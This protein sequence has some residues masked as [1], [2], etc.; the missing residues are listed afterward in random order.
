MDSPA[1]DF[2]EGRENSSK[3]LKVPPHLKSSEEGMHGNA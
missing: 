2:S 1:T 3:V